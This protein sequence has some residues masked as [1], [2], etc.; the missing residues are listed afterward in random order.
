MALT[1]CLIASRLGEGQT[2][3]VVDTEDL[4]HRHDVGGRT[5]VKAKVV[6]HTR[7]HDALNIMQWR[8][9]NTPQMA[10]RLTIFQTLITVNGE[11]VNDDK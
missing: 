7:P 5:K 8:F 11:C 2:S 10:G 9:T 3:L 1:I 6:L 4:R